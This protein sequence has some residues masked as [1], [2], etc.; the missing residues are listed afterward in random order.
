MT[1]WRMAGP[2][3]W[4]W[5]HGTRRELAP[6]W[7]AYGITVQPTTNDTTHGLARYL[8]DRQGFQRTGYL[9]PFLPTSSSST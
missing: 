2:W 3:R 6:V 4:H 1:R 7:A 8:I 9:L 5:L